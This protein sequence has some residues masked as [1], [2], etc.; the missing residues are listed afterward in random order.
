MQFKRARDPIEI[1]LMPKVLQDA[2]Q[3]KCRTEIVRPS[4]DD[5]LMSQAV[6]ASRR[7]VDAQTKCGCVIV[8]QDHQDLG[9][10]YNA[11]PRDVDDELL[12]N[13]RPDKYDWIIHAEVNAILNCSIKQQDT[14]AY[15][16][17]MP[18][19]RCAIFLWQAGVREIVY[20][21]GE[22]P[23]MMQN[24]H[25]YD[26]IEAFKYLTQ[27]RLRWRKHNLDIS[28]VKQLLSEFDKDGGV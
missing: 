26:N 27:H 7:S 8:N 21:D 28:H 4:W 20:M 6:L 3:G 1:H 14:I 5:Q 16:T 10:G 18:C 11:F 22:Y 15:V 13:L 2:Y 19:H 12:P 17:T 9:S 25:Y 23:N 24:N